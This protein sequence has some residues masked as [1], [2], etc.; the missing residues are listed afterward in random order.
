MIDKMIKRRIPSKTI[1]R[2]MALKRM[3]PIKRMIPIT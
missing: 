1:K 3:M 2:M